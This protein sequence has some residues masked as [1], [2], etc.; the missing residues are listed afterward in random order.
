MQTPQPSPPP[1][2]GPLAKTA[3]RDQLT[4]ARNRRPL[5][6]IG[7]AAHGIA[8][9][10]LAAEEVRRAATV[11]AYVAVGTEP[12]TSPLLDALHAAGTRILLPVLLPDGDLDWA[13]YAG[14]AALMPARY[15]MLEPA[16]PRLGVD[17]IATPDAVL[18]PGL[19]VS[20]TGL[21][22]GRGGGSY[23]RALARVPAGT[24]TCVLLYDDEVGRE[25]PVEAHDRAVTAAVSPA[26]LVRF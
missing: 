11:A 1:L 14:D 25:V 15:G 19:A 7:Q 5:V 16:G 24:F 2:G 23:D 10:L 9:H 17:A 20:D 3:L 18:V 12:G 26:G 6:E 13:A 22:L 21:R 8:A 4:T